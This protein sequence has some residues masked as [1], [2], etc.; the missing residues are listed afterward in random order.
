LEFWLGQRLPG[1]SVQFW[2]KKVS[3]TQLREQRRLNSGF[4]QQLSGQ[5]RFDGWNPS[6]RGS[7]WMKP[8]KIR[9]QPAIHLPGPAQDCKLLTRFSAITKLNRKS[10][11]VK[12]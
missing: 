8:L 10:W 3:N 11:A 2:L 1:L 4:A 9:F 12:S 5:P 7:K 6:E